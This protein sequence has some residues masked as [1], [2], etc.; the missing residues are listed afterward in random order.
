[1]ARAGGIAAG[2][3]RVEGKTAVQK[4][5]LRADRFS[6]HDIDKVDVG[7][8][9]GLNGS[10]GALPQGTVDIDLL[11]NP[12]GHVD[13]RRQLTGS[14]P[15]DTVIFPGPTSRFPNTASRQRTLLV[16]RNLAY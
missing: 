6:P 1:M 13:F 10:T 15:A 11:K 4:E 8:S 2:V 14:H 7:V 12:F 5:V 3:L 9:S 16:N